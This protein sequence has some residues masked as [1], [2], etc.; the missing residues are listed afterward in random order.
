M[1]AVWRSNLEEVFLLLVR[2]AKMAL[3]HRI[4]DEKLCYLRG[5]WELPELQEMTLY[6]ESFV[7]QTS[8]NLMRVGAS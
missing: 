2:S 6:M 8:L 4:N 7:H 3:V 5:P 1:A